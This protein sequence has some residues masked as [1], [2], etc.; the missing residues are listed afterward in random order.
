[1][2]ITGTGYAV[3]WEDGERVVM[4]PEVEEARFEKRRAQ[5]LADRK[6]AKKSLTGR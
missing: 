6:V 2:R 1:M 4:T 3:E 5:L